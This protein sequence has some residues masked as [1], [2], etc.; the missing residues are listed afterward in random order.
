MRRESWAAVVNAAKDIN[1]AESQYYIGL[2]QYRQKEYKRSLETLF[3]LNKSYAVY[4]YW[5]GKSFLLIA[6]NYLALNEL[7]QAKATLESV[8]TNSPLPEMKA[9]ARA[10]LQEKDTDQSPIKKDSTSQKRN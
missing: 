3:G 6:D 2:I 1:A 10:K 4:D 8:I 7:F 9:A 5:L